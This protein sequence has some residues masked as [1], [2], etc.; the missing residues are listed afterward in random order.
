[1]VGMRFPLF[2]VFA[3][4]FALLFVGS[5][6]YEATEKELKSLPDFGKPPV[7]R[8][9]RCTACRASVIELHEG[10]VELQRR[11]GGQKYVKEYD[12]L[13]MIEAVC[14]DSKLSNAAQKK[15]FKRKGLPLFPLKAW[16]LQRRN[17]EATT[18]FSRDV[19]ISRIQGN[20]VN[21]FLTNM[22]GEII[23]E[24]DEELFH[25]FKTHGEE[26]IHHLINAICGSGESVLRVCEDKLLGNEEV[27]M[28]PSERQRNGEL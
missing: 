26:G 8:K 5:K 4:E 13:E 24:Y 14:F 16:G 25:G 22:C 10:L 23:G 1:M 21:N 3:F 28:I 2:Y 15:D 9:L 11:K 17:N 7:Y 20:W 18:D 19:A 27:L 6:A 12:R